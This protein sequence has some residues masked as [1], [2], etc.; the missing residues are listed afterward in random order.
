MSKAGPHSSPGA[1]PSSGRSHWVR[2]TAAPP[3]TEPTSSGTKQPRGKRFVE[4][5]R[6]SDAQRTALVDGLA[7]GD[8]GDAES[9]ALFAA[10]MEYDLARFRELFAE[11]QQDPRSPAPPPTAI[12]PPALHKPAYDLV[13]LARAAQAL[14]ERI[15]ELDADG[16]A[17][18]QRALTDAD[19]FKRA[20]GPAYLDALRCELQRLATVGGQPAVSGQAAPPNPRTK[21]TPD[22]SDAARRFVLR[23]ASTF[24]D[25]FEL[26]VT[27]QR[28]SPFLLTLKALK[29]ATSIRIPVD[30]RT[31]ARILK[32]A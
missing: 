21:P 30:Q 5:Y 14:A 10:A 9:R 25:C 31:L 29:A 1:R 27:A 24:R 11:S 2:T 20:Y 22:V 15:D 7:E 4:P 12:R 28:S 26:P 17:Q 3:S 6:L 23:A 19:P 8:V 16:A 18:L 13:G 32:E